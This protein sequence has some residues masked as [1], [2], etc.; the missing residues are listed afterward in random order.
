MID[1]FV[2]LKSSGDTTGLL[3]NSFPQY[4]GLL[5]TKDRILASRRDE[6]AKRR[7]VEEPTPQMIKGLSLDSNSQY[8]QEHEKVLRNQRPISTGR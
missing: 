1:S 5:S 6:F 2:C 4:F 7:V 3:N 8:A